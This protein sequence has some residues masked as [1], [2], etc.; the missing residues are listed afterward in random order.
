MEASPSGQLVR[1]Q[2]RT[3]RNGAQL[4]NSSTDYRTLGETYYFSKLKLFIF[5]LVAHHRREPSAS[6][7]YLHSFLLRLSF[8]AKLLS[9]FQ[10]GLLDARNHGWFK[11]RESHFKVL[12]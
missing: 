1:N 5:G 8:A 11:A 9:C 4:G 12:I 2:V 10:V 3:R 7:R 6:T